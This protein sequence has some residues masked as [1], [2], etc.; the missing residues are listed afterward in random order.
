MLLAAVQLTTV[1]QLTKITKPD[2]DLDLGS[3]FIYH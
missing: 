3:K 2:M 1:M